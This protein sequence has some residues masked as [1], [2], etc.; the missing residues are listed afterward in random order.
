MVRLKE[1]GIRALS[2]AVL[3]AVILGAVL[4]D[5]ISEFALLCVIGIGCQIE[6]LNI[7][8][9][10]GLRSLR[11]LSAVGS[12]VLL[13]LFFLTDLSYILAF[14]AIAL[15]VVRF[16]SELYTRH[17]M[18]VQNIA[19]DLFTSLYT[20]IPVALASTLEGRVVAALFV[21]VWSNDVGAYLVGVTCG[22]HKLFERLSPK[23]SWEGAVG[24]ILIATSV[25]AI[26]GNYVFEGDIW[27]WGVLG[28][29]TAIASIYG[30]LFESMIK[31]SIGIKDSGNVIPGHGGM[32]DRFDAFLFA[33][34]VFW[35]VYYL[36]FPVVNFAQNC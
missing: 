14:C 1:M 19:L 3:V 11:V 25:G 33:A 32:L 5:P 18:P 9:R 10:E 4:F 31:R 2:G 22:K 17:P 16:S 29:A 21:L 36:L 6:L 30:D 24:G 27:Q 20:I 35:I 12:A 8:K 13:C 26:I 23:K 7:I 28:F 34:P 15:I